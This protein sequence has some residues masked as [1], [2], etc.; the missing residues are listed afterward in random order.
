MNDEVY[1]WHWDKHKSFLQVD[2][3]ILGVRNQAYWKYQKWKVCNIFAI[4]QKENVKDEV[5]FL[6]QINVKG[7]FKVIQS[8][9]VC[10]W[11]GMPKLLKITSLLF[12]N[13]LRKKCMMKLFFCMQIS[14]RK[15]SCKLI[16]W[17]LRKLE[18]KLIFC[19]QINIKVSTS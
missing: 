1:F 3:T 13:I 8:F 11:P 7:F 16:L 2:T 18:M 14:M 17:F 9:K 12:C 15:V 6:P 10:V 4:S 5:D 19:M